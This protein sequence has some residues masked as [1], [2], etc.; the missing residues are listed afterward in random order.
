MNYK[1]KKTTE[2]NYTKPM[3][4]R[5]TKE[6]SNLVKS[7]ALEQHTT[8]SEIVRTAIIEYINHNTSDTQL[9][10]SSITENTNKIKYLENKIEVLALLDMNLVKYIM[11]T[12]P[13]N[14]ANTPQMVEMLYEK[15]KKDCGSSL[16]SNHNGILESI[17]LD[18]YEKEGDK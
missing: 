3:Q 1:S 12:L 15:F 2:A 18:T 6:I 11:K 10:Y 4:V 7:K 9:L 17:I 8:E 5:L 14:T 16:K 13:I